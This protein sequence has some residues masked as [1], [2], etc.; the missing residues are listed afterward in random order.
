M[1]ANERWEMFSPQRQTV[2]STEWW[3][4][5][6]DARSVIRGGLMNG[7]HRCTDLY[8]NWR[9]DRSVLTT[10]GHRGQLNITTH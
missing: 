1:K 8:Q 10:M 9:H 3:C 4:S 5:G 6:D 7:V 2:A